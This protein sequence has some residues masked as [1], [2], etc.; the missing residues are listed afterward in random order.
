MSTNPPAQSEFLRLEETARLLRYQ[1]LTRGEVEAKF[2]SILDQVY[3][4]QASRP[5]KR[6]KVECQ[7]VFVED[8]DS[9]PRDN[10]CGVYQVCKRCRQQRW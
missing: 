9:G 7:H 8:V 4:R 10:G 1:G 6:A 3:A 2:T 5:V